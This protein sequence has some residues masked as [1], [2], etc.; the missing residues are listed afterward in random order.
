LPVQLADLLQ[1]G[2]QLAVVGQTTPHIGDLL[3]READL[4]NDA[5]GIADG[6]DGDR[7]AFAA[8]A[9]GAAG[10]MA[11]DALEQGATEDL[12]GLGETSEEAVALLNT[13]LL[14]HH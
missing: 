1:S 14:L 10:A 7:M 5:A 9:C 6:E 8:G 2:L 13:L 11:D 4:T 12:A 3:L